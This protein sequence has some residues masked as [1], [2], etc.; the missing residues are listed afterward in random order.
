M[1]PPRTDAGKLGMVNEPQS[2]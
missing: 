2:S 1:S